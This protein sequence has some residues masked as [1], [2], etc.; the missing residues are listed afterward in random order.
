MG[1]I[2]SCVILFAVFLVSVE[3]LYHQYLLS[4]EVPNLYDWFLEVTGDRYMILIVQGITTVFLEYFAVRRL[5]KDECIRMRYQNCYRL[6]MAGIREIWK[7]SFSVIGI[8]AIITVLVYLAG[9]GINGLHFYDAKPLVLLGNLLFMDIVC[10]C[11]LLS[12]LLMGIKEKASVCFILMLLVI[13]LG[14]SGSV[15]GMKSATARFTWIGNV[16]VPSLENRYGIHVLYWG[17]WILGSLFTALLKLSVSWGKIKIRLQGKL[18]YTVSTVLAVAMVF[19][20][21]GFFFQNYADLSG[22]HPVTDWFLYFAGFEKPDIFLLMYLFYHVPVWT[23]VYFF[24]TQFFSMYA[25]Q[26]ILRGGNMFRFYWKLLK[27]A[28]AL[29]MVYYGI[30]LAALGLSGLA[31]AGDA[32]GAVPVTGTPV[33]LF[34]NL[35]LQDWLLL[36]CMFGIWLADREER[37]TGAVGVITV[38]LVLSGLAAKYPAAAAW[39]PLTG[40][41]YLSHSDMQEMT[42]FAQ[43]VF[44]AVAVL[45]VGYMLVYKYGEIFSRKK[46]GGII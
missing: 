34:I 14:A 9:Q 23:G 20:A 36:L 32:K 5:V 45:T 27:A 22:I 10:G 15:F 38:H 16:M 30:G 37:H 1:K 21:Y 33:L 28:A 2:K 7:V 18:F 13:N 41:V 46:G 24:M 29:T 25:L 11:L 19:A 8:L 40:G 43:T 42:A 26:Y 6:V 3:I 4:G 44:L 17:V 35:L 31:V 39:L 12:L